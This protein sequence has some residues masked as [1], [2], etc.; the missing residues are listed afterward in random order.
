[1]QKFYRATC[2]ISEEGATFLESIQDQL[3]YYISEEVI[4]KAPNTAPKL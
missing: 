3:P 1:L 2:E 4:A